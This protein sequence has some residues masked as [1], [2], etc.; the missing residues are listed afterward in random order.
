MGCVVTRTE[1]EL[2]AYVHQLEDYLR[3]AVFGDAPDPESAVLLVRGAL[4][5]DDEARAADLAEATE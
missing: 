2:H 4:A 3:Q 1:I 5:A